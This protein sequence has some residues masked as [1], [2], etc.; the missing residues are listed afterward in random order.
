MKQ[1][2]KITVELPDDNDRQG[3]CVMLGDVVLP[4][5]SADLILEDKKP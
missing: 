2:L 3:L 4:I 1:Y 5:L